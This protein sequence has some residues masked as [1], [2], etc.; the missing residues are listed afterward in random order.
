VWELCHEHLGAVGV[1]LGCEL[2][3]GH[4]G[5][6]GVCESCDQ[7]S[8]RCV[9]CAIRCGGVC[10]VCSVHAWLWCGVEAVVASYNGVNVFLLSSCVLVVLRAASG[11]VVVM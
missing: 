2:C 6:V 4:P 3:S 8:M 7:A 1:S 5:A 9:R 10:E 11:A